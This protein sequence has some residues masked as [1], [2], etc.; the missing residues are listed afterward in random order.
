V[1][2]I[3]DEISLTE[4]RTAK[5]TYSTHTRGKWGKKTLFTVI[6]NNKDAVCTLLIKGENKAELKKVKRV[7]K[8]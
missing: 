3:I 1:L 6:G 8:V 5:E 2:I 7:L 4:V